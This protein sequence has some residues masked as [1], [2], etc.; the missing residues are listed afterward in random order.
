MMLGECQIHGVQA[1][2]GGPLHG[3]AGQRCRVPHSPVREDVACGMLGA[4]G[5]KACCDRRIHVLVI[6]QDASAFPPGAGGQLRDSGSNGKLWQGTP[7]VA[8]NQ[9]IVLCACCKLPLHSC[10]GATNGSSDLICQYPLK[11]N[12]HT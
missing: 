1:T 3:T 11:V 6:A 10:T 8:A 4:C 5:G 7:H 9:R 2:R 12:A